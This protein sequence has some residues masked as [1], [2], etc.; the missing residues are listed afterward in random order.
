MVR[1]SIAGGSGQR[2][3]VQDLT[4]VEAVGLA[5]CELRKGD[6]VAPL[7]SDDGDLTIRTCRQLRSV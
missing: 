1:E 6:D 3:V 5:L 2:I 7:R 4:S